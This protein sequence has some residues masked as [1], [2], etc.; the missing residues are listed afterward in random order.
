[1]Q[2]FA[3]FAW[4]DR[5]SMFLDDGGYQLNLVGVDFTAAGEELL[6]AEVFGVVKEDGPGID[7]IAPGAPNFLIAGVNGIA[8]IVVVDETDVF[9]V[10]AH[11]KGGGGNDYVDFAIHEG[12]LY[13]MAFLRL[14]AS[15]IKEGFFVMRLQSMSD[16]F[17]MFA[18]GDVDDARFFSAGDSLDQCLHFLS[19]IVEHFDAEPDVGAVKALHDNAR[20]AHIQALQYLG[21]DGQGGSGG[22]GKHSGMTEFFDDAAQAQV[23]GAK[24]VAP[25]TD[26]VGFIDDEKRGMSGFQ[27]GKRFLVIELFGG[28]EE[29]LEIAV[30]ERFY[31]LTPFTCVDSGVQ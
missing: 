4:T 9:F 22:E 24:I 6:E 25:F 16:F 18:C 15:V 10:D 30:V 28:E 29:K 12:L 11:A 3:Q 26:T 7:A 31:Y 1:M 27:L 2:F 17:R 5:F 21:A 13:G 8:D 23:F 19:F 20:V 14:H